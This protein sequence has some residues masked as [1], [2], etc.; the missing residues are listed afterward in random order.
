MHSPPLPQIT[1]D[2]WT[3]ARSPDLGSINAENQQA[4]D[5][6]I[7]RAADHSWQLGACVRN[8]AVGGHGR[9]LYRWESAQ[10]SKPS[11]TPAGIL[12]QADTHFGESH[13]GLQAPFVIKH[14]DQYHMFYG[15]WRNICSACSADGKTFSRK[16]N[17]RR[18]SQTFPG[19][20]D[21]LLRD[22]MVVHWK[23]RYFMYYTQEQG[24]RGAICARSSSDLLT[25]SHS[26]TV[27]RGGNA[28]VGPADAECAFVFAKEDSLLLFRWDERGIT[29]I[30]R[31]TDPLNFGVDH[32][33]LKV[34]ELPFE[35]V[36][37][38]QEK[39]RFYLASL[40]EDYTGIKLACMKW[41]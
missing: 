10:L 31:S 21:A 22:P 26:Q 33:Q 38:I 23:G 12:L 2:W 15:G 4:V 11:W 1:S 13:G 37:I 35:C 16:L 32:D 18:E 20:G 19:A 7:W 17:H 28:G 39:N 40:H 5:F 3:I 14:Y 8:T 24:G 25:W 30:Y 36:R 41:H 27:N 6:S 9:L 29:T 34:G